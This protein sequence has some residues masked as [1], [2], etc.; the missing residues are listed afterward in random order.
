[1][2]VSARRRNLK[3]IRAGPRGRAMTTPLDRVYEQLLVVRCQTGDE[4]AFAE[5][6]TRHADRLRRYV[7]RLLCNDHAAADDVVQDVWL[8]VLRSGARLRDPAAFPTWLLRI[9]RDRV[10]RVL[11]R[12]R[13]F[14]TITE[15]HEPTA[16][17]PTFTADDAAAIRAGL[18][19]LDP[20][21]REVVV[22]R[23]FEEMTCDEI[24]AVVGCPPGTVRS[25]LHH[26]KRTL[27]D[28]LTERD[29]P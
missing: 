15:L 16:D 28:I 5:L 24:A 6:V 12:R 4:A 23:Y 14:A 13:D 7:G 27:K 22:L 10:F 3:Y 11:R 9:A 19:R 2:N 17:E 26:A 18:D 20:L 21:R 8:D 1:M 29:I 25:R